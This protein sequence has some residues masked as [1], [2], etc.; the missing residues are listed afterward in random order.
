MTP[1]VSLILALPLLGAGPATRPAPVRTVAAVFDFEPTGEADKAL[2]VK[3]REAIQMKLARHE[4]FVL[5]DHFSLRD[6]LTDA[7]LTVT[8]AT[9]LTVMETLGRTALDA[10]LLVWGKVHRAGDRFTIHAR[11]LDLSGER[12]DLYI[13]RAFPANGYR[14]IPFAVQRIINAIRRDAD[15]PDPAVDPRDPGPQKPDPT[16]LARPNLVKNGDFEAG[17]TAPDHWQSPDGLVSH[18]VK[19]PDRPGK[20][21]MFDT[22]VDAGQWKAWHRRFTLGTTDPPPT[23][24]RGTGH[25]YGTV[26]GSYGGYL[27]VKDFIP[28]KPGVTYRLC[29]D[30]RSTGAGAKVFVKGYAQYPDQRREV[31]RMYK[32]CKAES[33]GRRWEHFTRTFNPTAKTPD[34]KWMKVE[35]FCY[36][37][38]TRYFF[39]NVHLSEEPAPPASSRQE[40]GGRR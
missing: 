10:D 15:A 34:V 29:F 26:A 33:G 38:P 16:I 37:P 1:A 23:P 28:V 21:L 5:V 9:R 25:K 39:D 24:R 6:V 22:D 2:G 14:E 40:A 4:E 27:Y 19:A 7:R 11:A 31:Y 8:H 3:I 18:W 17:K 30:Y 36:W 32:A 13:D 35:L 12:A 20:C